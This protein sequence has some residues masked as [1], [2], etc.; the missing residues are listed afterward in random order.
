MTCKTGNF[1]FGFSAQSNDEPPLSPTTTTTLRPNPD[2]QC[3]DATCPPSNGNC[4]NITNTKIQQCKCNKGYQGENCDDIN[5]CSG[6]NPCKNNGKCEN[7]PGTF[8]CDCRDT[9]FKGT[10]CQDTCNAIGNDCENRGVCRKQN[11]AFTCDCKDTGYT[12][13]LCNVDVN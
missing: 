12:G 1:A 11:G 13:D 2:F 6:I 8:K 4:K 9:G 5:E 7:Q 10:T 3:N